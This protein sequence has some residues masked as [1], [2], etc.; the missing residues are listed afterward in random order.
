[1]IQTDKKCCLKKKCYTARTNSFCLFTVLFVLSKRYLPRI[2]NMSK[3]FDQTRVGDEA[4]FQAFRTCLEV[5]VFSSFL[6]SLP[7]WTTLKPRANLGPF[8]K[9]KDVVITVLE[10]SS[11]MDKQKYLEVSLNCKKA[12]Q[13]KR[14][15]THPSPTDRWRGAWHS[16]LPWWEY[17]TRP[18][19][20]QSHCGTHWSVY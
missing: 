10:Q 14:K 2:P 12:A 8:N 6:R 15:A 4:G 5:P 13:P 19:W 20:G 7:N 11:K 18:S 1:M 9:Q 3:C 16:Q 17:Y